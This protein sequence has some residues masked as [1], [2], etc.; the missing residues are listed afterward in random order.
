MIKI[1]YVE[2]IKSLREDN[3]LKQKDIAKILNKSQQGYAHLENR[4][5]KFTVEDII[6]LA[7][8]YKVSSDYIL[9]LDKNTDNKN[10]K[11]NSNTSNNSNKHLT[12]KQNGKFNKIEN[13][14]M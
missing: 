9:G 8:Y 1:D 2:R 12:I 14:N 6:T 5:A 3:D 13:V 10:N 11:T 7:K 4:K